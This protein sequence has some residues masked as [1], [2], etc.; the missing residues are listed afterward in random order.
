MEKPIELD[1]IPGTETMPLLKSGEYEI[2]F[3]KIFNFRCGSSDT[4][5]V[6]AKRRENKSDQR[7]I[8]R[9]QPDPRDE[10]PADDIL[11]LQQMDGVGYFSEEL[12]KKN[13]TDKFTFPYVG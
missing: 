5:S 4:L 1:K 6:I 2:F 12:N 8:L 7:I 3:D 13:S 10:I 11:T 9:Y